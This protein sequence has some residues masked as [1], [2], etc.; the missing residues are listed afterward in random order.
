MMMVVAVEVVVW[1]QSC[2]T[3]LFSHNIDVGGREGRR[4][5]GRRCV[6][7]MGWVVDGKHSKFR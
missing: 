6:S 3:L 2:D 1:S 7:V 4:G 5:R